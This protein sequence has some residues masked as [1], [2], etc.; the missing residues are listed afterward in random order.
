MRANSL[1]AM[2]AALFSMLP[3]VAVA[4][5]AAPG[6]LGPTGYIYTPDA[7]VTGA[8][9]V[10]FGYHHAFGDPQQIPVPGGGRRTHQPGLHTFGINFGVGN[11]LEIGGALLHTNDRRE[12]VDPAEADLHRIDGEEWLL[13]GKLALLRPG[14]R[15]QLVAGVIDAL[16]EFRRTPYVYGATDI[17]PY[18]PRSRWI[19]LPKRFQA[20]AGWAT[21]IL[22]GFFLNAGI[23]VT[24][25]VEMMFEWLDNDLPGVYRTGQQ[26]VAGAR[27]R[28]DRLPGLA[29]DV[30]ATSVT[31][32]R[33]AVGVSYTF[34]PFRRSGNPASEPE[35]TPGKG[36]EKKE[37]LLGP[38]TTALFPTPR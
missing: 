19:R 31:A 33:F 7:A 37:T 20:G 38:V 32:P 21:G 17:G 5:D 18:L 23:P 9:G 10:A 16:N 12:L 15:F 35:E 2:A 6:V 36:G 1:A 26:F 28:S 4:A 14:G 34:H 3:A 29:I 30:A 24:P 25:N 11:R 8:G 13:N 22:D 27:L